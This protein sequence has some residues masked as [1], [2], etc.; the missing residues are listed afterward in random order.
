VLPVS[1]VVGSR[2]IRRRGG[3]NLIDARQPQT[4]VLDQPQEVVQ[5]RVVIDLYTD[6]RLRRDARATMPAKAARA[7]SDN[8]PATRNS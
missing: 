8:R 3:R 2:R 7:C 5:L 1:S 6:D 4:E